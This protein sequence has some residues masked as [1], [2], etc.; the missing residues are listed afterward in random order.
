MI[1]FVRGILESTGNDQIVVRMAGVGLQVHV[2][3]SVAQTVGNVGDE[4]T[5]YTTLI[6][7]DDSLTLFGFPTQEGKKLFDQLLAVSG[8]GP[9]YALGLLSAMTPNEAA[10]AIVSGNADALS[11]APGIGKRTAARIVV[12]LQAKLQR[13]WEAVAIESWDAYGEVIAALQ[14]LGY[15]AAEVQKA[16]SALGDVSQ[17]PLEEQV[18]QALQQLARE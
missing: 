1:A 16:A 13:E 17:L 10:M 6:I 15:S 18:R 7:R 9:K 11:A 4:V 3:A 12:D 5:L 8:V 14:A 2:P